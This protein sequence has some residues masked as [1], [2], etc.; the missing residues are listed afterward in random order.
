MDKIFSNYEAKLS[1]QIVK[2]LGKSMIRLCSMGACAV[3]GMTDQDTLSE[4]L[5]SDPFLSSA[6]QRFT[7][8]LY[9]RFGL[10]L[11]PRSI[12]LIT[13]RHYL[14]ERG[15]TNGDDRSERITNSSE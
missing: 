3:L 13:D 10:F 7:C 4:N 12:G 2:S 1:G 5:E 11:A 14:T 9:Y 6:L 8:D 15:I